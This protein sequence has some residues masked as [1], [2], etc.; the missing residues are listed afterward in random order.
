M[1]EV[2]LAGKRGSYGGQI[3]VAFARNRCEIYLLFDGV[4]KKVRGLNWLSV[5]RGR[6]E[7]LQ[8]FKVYVILYIR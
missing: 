7:K 4:A 1:D 2:G 3:A 5:G 8:A 6:F